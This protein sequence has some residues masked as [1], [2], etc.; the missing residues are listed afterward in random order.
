[1]SKRDELI[2]KYATDLEEKCGLT[3]D[4]DLLTK[5]TVGLGPSIYN[6]DASTVSGSDEKELATVKNNFLINKLGLDNGADLD[7]AIAEAIDT[8]GKSNRNKYRAVVYYLLV[9]HFKKE[10]VYN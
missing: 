1:M 2:A 6:A 4:M 5:V 8:Y 3:P 9:K 7:K 10:S